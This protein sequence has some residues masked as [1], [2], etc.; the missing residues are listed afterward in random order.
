MRAAQLTSATAV[1]GRAYERT[2]APRPAASVR[3]SGSRAILV[4]TGLVAFANVG[5]ASM[6]PGP[7]VSVTV[8]RGTM[9]RWSRRHALQATP[10]V[11][12]SSSW[13]QRRH[14]RSRYAIG[15]RSKFC[16]GERVDTKLLSL[17]QAKRDKRSTGRWLA[18]AKEA[19]VQEETAVRASPTRADRG[20][21][22]KHGRSQHAASLA[23]A[24]CTHAVT[25]CGLTAARAPSMPVSALP[26]RAVMAD[27]RSTPL[28]R[29]PRSSQWTLSVVS[30]RSTR[31]SA[32]SARCIPDTAETLAGFCA[33][34]P[35]E[36]GT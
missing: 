15:S 10:A 35:F 9:A 26:A 34:R 28:R 1:E 6:V 31:T 8:P 14:Q 2:G 7:L 32:R 27:R 19:R 25:R 3:A 20:P 30:A 18:R 17:D 24:R 4:L 21:V 16:C 5:A 22:W 11:S 12:C 33:L 36:G 13:E 29:S 23:L